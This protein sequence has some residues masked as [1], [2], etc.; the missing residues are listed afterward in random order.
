MTTSRLRIFAF[1]VISVFGSVLLFLASAE[2]VLRFLPVEMSVR[3]LPL[4][5]THPVLRAPPNTRFSHS[6]GWHFQNPNSGRINNDGFFN[7]QDYHRNGPRPLIVVVGDSYIEA[8]MVPYPETIQGRLAA[9]PT[10][11]GRT[12]SFAMS[13]AP[14][15]QYLAWIGY[16]RDAYAPD[17]LIIVVVSNDFDE[18]HVAYKERVGF[19]HYAEDQDGVLQLRLTEYNPSIWRILAMESAFVR[20]LVF[21]LRVRESW[22]RLKRRAAKL[23]GSVPKQPEPAYVGNN[24][25]TASGERQARSLAVVDAFLRD[26]PAYSGLAPERVLFVL[27]GLRSSIYYPGKAAAEGRSYFT[28]MRQ[29]LMERARDRGYAV[30]DLHEVFQAD[31]GKNRRRFEFEVDAHWSSYGHGVAARAIM[32]LPWYARISGTE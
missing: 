31:Y 17:A 4:D 18:S 12:Y 7:E 29:Y 25:A 26:L 5:A 27:D 9:D 15:S 23:F 10:G 28:I 1:A 8:K 3:T 14:L 21:H 32:R 30:I 24:P 16:A 6:V 11:S 13:G 22:G 20:Y 19:Y 2:L